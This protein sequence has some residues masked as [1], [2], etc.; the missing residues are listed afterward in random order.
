MT[1]KKEKVFVQDTIVVTQARNGRRDIGVVINGV[2][3]Q[4]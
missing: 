2:L 3:V 4:K 1:Q